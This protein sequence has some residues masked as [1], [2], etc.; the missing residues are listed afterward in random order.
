MGQLSRVF[1]G[2]ISIL[3]HHLRLGD[4]LK[5]IFPEFDRVQEKCLSARSSIPQKQEEVGKAF[6]TLSSWLWK[7]GR[8]PF[9]LSPQDL[10]QNEHDDETR[11][12]SPGSDSEV[13]ELSNTSPHVPVFLKSFIRSLAKMNLM[14]R[15]EANFPDRVL[16]SFNY[17]N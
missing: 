10:G 9:P 1:G 14:M 17:R 8:E 3:D 16:A 7:W 13:V 11:A 12:Q 15:Q 5:I 6:G 4:D 2:N